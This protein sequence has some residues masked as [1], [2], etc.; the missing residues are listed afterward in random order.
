M[1]QPTT[2]L[3]VTRLAPN[4]F[5]YT[6]TQT[7]QAS[8]VVLALDGEF[9]LT[10]FT[11]YS[12]EVTRTISNARLAPPT[13]AGDYN[14]AIQSA[15]QGLYNCLFKGTADRE[16]K[17][18]R[19]VLEAGK[20]PLLISTDTPEVFWEL[21]SDGNGSLGLRLDVGRRLKARL[22]P[23]LR[24]RPQRRWR[25]LI[26]ANPTADDPSLALP[27][28]SLEGGRIRDWLSNHGVNCDDYLEGKDATYD[29]VLNKLTRHEYD[30]FHYAGHVVPD[31][32]QTSYAFL[33]NGNVQFA[34]RLVREQAR[35]I[36]IVFLNG[37]W[38][39]QAQP[40]NG[41]IVNAAGSAPGRTAAIEVA[42]TETLTDAF[43]RKGA[44][45]V[46]GSLFAPTDEGASAFAES[47][48]E[49]IL[50]GSSSG[51]A[52]RVA[53]NAVMN[54]PECT[55]AWASFVMYGDP[56][57]APLRDDLQSILRTVG[58]RRGDFDA[59]AYKVL[60]GAQLLAKDSRLVGSAELVSAMLSSPGGSLQ[61]RLMKCG[62]R[63]ERLGEELRAVMS[64]PV[65]NREETL[66]LSESARTLVSEARKAATGRPPRITEMDLVR[67]F[68]RRAGG[69]AK[70][71]VGRFVAP[72]ML[73]PEAPSV[74][75]TS[76]VLCEKI[77]PLT[78]SDCDPVAWRILVTAAGITIRNKN[79]R[80]S[81]EDLF[82]AMRRDPTGVLGRALLR[83]GV[84]P[85]AGEPPFNFA[86]TQI[87]CHDDVFTI[88]KQAK[89]IANSARRVTLAEPDLLVAFAWQGGGDIGHTYR[90]RGAVL[91]M[92]TSRL[93][94]DTGRLDFARFDDTAAG[95][96]RGAIAIAGKSGRDIWDRQDLLY[97]ML[98]TEGAALSRFIN[99]AGGNAENLAGIWRTRLDVGMK[100]KGAP[101][102]QA[103][104]MTP[105]MQRLLFLAEQDA[106]VKG[107]HH[108]R[109][110]HLLRA[111]QSDG[112]G[113]GGE[114]LIREGV[115]LSELI[116]KVN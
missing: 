54:R 47:F 53:R 94:N 110:L 109:E 3:D 33:L 7:G 65:V 28:A 42:K 74:A 60:E 57:L 77:G 10:S 102:D 17:D 101:G 61:D 30:I 83:F 37:C 82:T 24:S 100:I 68:A 66:Q 2:N 70:A 22:L 92:L 89:S 81:V 63:H 48:Y 73:D 111:F 9:D 108:V 95:M 113:T 35:G 112:G 58:L 67:G 115:R 85:I 88:L 12:S 41:P 43:L 59:A 52:M 46:V 26:I 78:R 99:E 97:G 38:S 36:P 18:L 19:D 69:R 84:A 64:G 106:D 11:H 23:P 20:G 62:L 25:A 72:Q 5:K 91:E 114:F 103:F 71:V 55:A 98:T 105:A 4:H 40:L 13:A 45:V 14:R 6:L 51:E 86:A 21:L 79:G 107:N 39:G 15:G 44:Q 49:S 80:M 87:D 90:E 56:S 75:S 1:P 16:F 76:L 50:D 8:P 116:A 29:N 93:F 31:A 104:H 32:K 96:V 34:A 27:G